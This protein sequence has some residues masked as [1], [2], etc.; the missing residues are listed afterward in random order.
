[1]DSRSGPIKKNTG[2]DVRFTVLIL[3]LALF[4]APVPAALAQQASEPLAEA[5]APYALYQDDV[6]W[7]AR[8][9]IDTPAALDEALDRAARHQPETLAQSWIAYAALS[10]A[11]SPAFVAGVRA[12]VRAASRAAVLRRLNADVTYAR[13]RP[14]GAAE[15]IQVVLQATTADSARIAAAADRFAAMGDILR[16]APWANVA[17]TDRE[18]RATRLRT[19]A[20]R[21]FTPDVLLRLGVGAG[22]VNPLANPNALGGRFYW[23]ALAGAPSAAPYP[24]AP[25]LRE[26]RAQAAL[27]DRA[28]TLAAFRIVDGSASSP[29]RVRALLANPGGA[30]CLTMALLQF[31]QCV[32]VTQFGYENAFCLS[33]HGLREPSACLSP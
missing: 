19:M 31:R 25:S 1:M 6:S 27:M 8:A 7:L 20:D 26:S 11:Q 16:T 13:N 12:R 3:G 15:A 24:Q 21:A 18:A 2:G 30:S 14:Q 23:D 29:V 4:L 28:L 33:R 10:A 32:S 5:A 17:L 9:P 22:F